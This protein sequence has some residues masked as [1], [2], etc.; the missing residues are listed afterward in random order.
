MRRR[1]AV[2]I[3]ILVLVAVVAVFALYVTRMADQT[4]S[5]SPSTQVATNTASPAT[6]APVATVSPVATGSA[7][8]AS[9]SATITG[10]LGYPSDFIPP[11]TIYALSVSDS[12]V[13]FSLNTPRYGNDP[14]APPTPGPPIPPYS[15][16]V[17]P[18]T[19]H[20]FGYRNDLGGGTTGPGVVVYSLYTVRCQQASPSPTGPCQEPHTLV[21]VT[22]RAGETAARIDLTD[23]FCNVPGSTC[24]PRPQ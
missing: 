2:A 17:P 15:L 24:P 20:V 22:V 5:P 13:Y 9:P 8:S 7:P 1:P 19:Y 6:S 18:G 4:A 11:L 16:S 10:R 21:P 14:S 23:W 12:R 3:A